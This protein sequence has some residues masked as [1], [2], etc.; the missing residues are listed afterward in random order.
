MRRSVVFSVL[1][2]LVLPLLLATAPAAAAEKTPGNGS[3]AAAVSDPATSQTTV[4]RFWSPKN[5][6][7]F[8]TMNVSERDTIISTFPLDEWTYEGPAYQAF[9]TQQPGTVPLYRF[10]SP[11]FRG[12]FYTSAEAEK[13]AVIADYDD[14]TWTFENTAY[15]VYP[16]DASVA[17]SL[18]VARFWSPTNRHHFYTASAEE[19]AR[20]KLYPADVWTYERF[21][22]R[23]PSSIALDIPATPTQYVA[24]VPVYVPP[25]YVPPVD[26]PPVYVPPVDVPSNVYYANCTDVR[27]QGKAPLY[28]GQPGYE[29]PRLDRD[30]DGVACE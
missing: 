27:N 8:Y 19:A 4:Y 18:P 24:P 2:A 23:V 6:T 25:V 22:F 29:Y 17:N 26:V 9:S 20:V 14:A 30:G 10:W 15:F 7:H 21:D 3:V 13:N 11:T 28:R 12:H 16:V 1:A 5:S